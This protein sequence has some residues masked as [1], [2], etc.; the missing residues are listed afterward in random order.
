MDEKNLPLLRELRA[1]LTT[2]TTMIDEI[3]SRTPEKEQTPKSS[4]TT[5]EGHLKLGP[6]ALNLPR[7][8]TLESILTVARKLEIPDRFTRR[9]YENQVALGWK[10]SFNQPVRH[11]DRYL[12]YSWKL[13]NRESRDKPKPRRVLELQPP[14]AQDDKIRADAKRQLEEFRRQMKR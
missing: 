12:R 10:D 6:L 7:E 2:A 8:F 1:I 5:T 13:E 9:W 3:L 14:S 11:P 4:T